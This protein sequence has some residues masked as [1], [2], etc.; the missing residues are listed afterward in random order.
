MIFSIQAYLEN[1]FDRRGL[2]DIDQYSVSISK[3]YDSSRHAVTETAFLAEMKR[4]RTSFY[5]RNNH[6]QRDTF[7]RRLLTLL[8]K[9]FKKKGCSSS[10]G[11]SQQKL[12]LPVVA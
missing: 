4:L 1:Y 11:R 10:Q 6:L 12:R 5:K 7:E 9:K 8:D 2:T 3:L